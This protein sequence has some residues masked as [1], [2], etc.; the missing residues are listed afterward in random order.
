MIGIQLVENTW[1]IKP[2]TF[3]ESV[4]FMISNGNRAEWSTIQGV[5]RGVI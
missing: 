5:I 2:I 3:E 4:V 1:S